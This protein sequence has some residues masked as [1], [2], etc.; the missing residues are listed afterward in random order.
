M[1]RKRRRISVHSSDRFGAPP[2]TLKAPVEAAPSQLSVLA[3][4]PDELVEE[5]G[6]G[7]ERIRELEGRFPVLWI[8]LEGLADVDLLQQLGDLFGLHKLAL[9]DTLNIPQ[10]PKLDDYTTHQYLS[11]IHI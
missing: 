9:E 8:N 1:I 4:S 10:R 6:V 3:Y 5:S 11:L 2:G 7:F